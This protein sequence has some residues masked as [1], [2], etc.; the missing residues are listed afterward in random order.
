MMS[1]KQL[2]FH[3]M[4]NDKGV[5][6]LCGRAGTGKSHVIDKVASYSS[7]AGIN[8]IGLAPTH[9]A[10]E[11]MGGKFDYS[12]TIKGFFVQVI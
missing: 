5:R 3:L 1:K 4:F 7:L 10:V 9:K 8:V 12:D 6:I 2:F 11:S